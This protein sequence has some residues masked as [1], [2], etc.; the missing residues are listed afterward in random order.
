MQPFVALDFETA[1]G[2][3]A[4]ACSIGMARFGEDGEIKK[5]FHSL[6]LPHMEHRF[7]HPANTWVHGIRADDVKDS[8]EWGDLVGEVKDFVGDAPLV[9]HNFGFDGSVLNQLADLYQHPPLDNHRYCTLR[10]ARRIYADLPKKSLDVVFGH[11]FPGEQLNHHNAEADAIAAGRIFSAMHRDSSLEDL[12]ALLAPDRRSGTAKRPAVSDASSVA[13]LVESF[14][15]SIA[16]RGE[17]IC[18]TGTLER[19]KRADMEEFIKHV[20]ATPSKNVTAKTT[21]LV[22]GVPN[23]TTWKEGSSASRKLE[24]AT[25]LYEKGAPIQV[26]SEEDFF[27]LLEE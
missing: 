26:L 8:P 17:N 9:A 11:L 22:V 4:S 16:L 14:G 21:L 13:A 3:R 10:L 12:D 25:Q 23:P 7:F 18:F 19:G 5:T 20:G 1:N 24:K 15:G 27:A 2:K 6:I